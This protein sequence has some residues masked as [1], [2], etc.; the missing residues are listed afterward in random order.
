MYQVAQCF[1]LML[2]IDVFFELAF[3][4]VLTI[5]FG[6]AEYF[7]IFIPTPILTLSSIV[8]ARESIARESHVL[9]VLFIF[10]QLEFMGAVTYFLFFRRDVTT[11]SE[12]VF[13]DW[14][15][16]AFFCK[17]HLDDVVQKL[18]KKI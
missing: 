5:A 4:I 8:I 13:T 18:T 3:I 11:A 7:G 10:L 17:Y 6:S 14:Y 12:F 16:F 1:S 9:M 2:K 15:A